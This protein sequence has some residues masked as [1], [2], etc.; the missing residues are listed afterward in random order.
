[1]VEE[2]KWSAIWIIYKW[3]TRMVI[4]TCKQY[5]FA[6]KQK[7]K[8]KTV[9]SILFSVARSIE[10]AASDGVDWAWNVNFPIYFSFFFYLSNDDDDG[11]ISSFFIP[12]ELYRHWV[13][14]AESFARRIEFRAETTVVLFNMQ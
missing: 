11:N 1:M 9:E 14:C 7:M 3:R 10:R 6:P 5:S 12:C 8:I 4:Y 2:R 13:L